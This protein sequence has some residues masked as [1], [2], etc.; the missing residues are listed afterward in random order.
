[1]KKKN[2]TVKELQAILDSPE[3]TYETYTKKD[4][5]LGARKVKKPKKVRCCQNGFFGQKHDCMKQPGN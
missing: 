5:S 3:G 4:G 1:M 2:P